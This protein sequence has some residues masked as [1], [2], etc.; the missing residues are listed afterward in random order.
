MTRAGWHVTVLE[1]V[2]LKTTWCAW[3]Q[4]CSF[5]TC[6]GFFSLWLCCQ[7]P[8]CSGL[9]HVWLKLRCLPFCLVGCKPPMLMRSARTKRSVCCGRHGDPFGFTW[10]SHTK[11]VAREMV[12]KASRMRHSVFCTYW[13]KRQNRSTYMFHQKPCQL[14]EQK[15]KHTTWCLSLPTGFGFHWVY[16]AEV[17]SRDGFAHDFF[18]TVR[19]GNRV[20]PYASQSEKIECLQLCLLPGKP[21]AWHK[22][23]ICEYLSQNWMN[24]KRDETQANIALQ[25]H[26]R[27]VDEFARKHEERGLQLRVVS[28]FTPPMLAL[29][30]EQTFFCSCALLA[31]EFPCEKQWTTKVTTLW[32]PARLFC[33]VFSEKSL[34]NVNWK[35]RE[36]RSTPRSLQWNLLRPL[37]LILPSMAEQGSYTSWVVEW[38]MK[39]WKCRSTCE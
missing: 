37:K 19:L 26:P 35:R 21:C 24:C 36:T 34:A 5:D 16:T 38:H 33:F 18:G 27:R 13:Q 22:R 17:H 30:R 23:G 31:D 4:K 1:T 3:S 29:Q 11:M 2:L 9:P 20:D 25:F 10:S 28:H 32:P 14:I 6:T 7:S 8:Y 15:I 39:G 12:A